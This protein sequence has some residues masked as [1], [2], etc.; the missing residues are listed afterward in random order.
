MTTPFHEVLGLE[1]AGEGVEPAPRPWTDLT[2]T[3]VCD[4]AP[5]ADPHGNYIATV[6]FTVG[7]FRLRGIRVYRGAAGALILN[8]PP[9]VVGGKWVETVE[10]DRGTRE[11]LRADV[12]AELARVDGGG[13][14]QPC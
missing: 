3:P 2:V 1:P 14:E 10:M 12:A 8:F 11:Q 4:D 13:G 9:R 5:D 7:P 6:A